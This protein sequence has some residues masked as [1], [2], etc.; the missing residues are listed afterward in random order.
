MMHYFNSKMPL[1]KFISITQHIFY[2]DL[3]GF[4][5]NH[6]ATCLPQ[7]IHPNPCQLIRRNSNDVRPRLRQLKRR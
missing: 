2:A 1:S 4:S 5:R 7:I 6:L 3:V